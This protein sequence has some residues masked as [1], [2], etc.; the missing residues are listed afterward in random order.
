MN[1]TW[2]KLY[3]GLCAMAAVAIA[4]VL[5]VDYFGYQQQG[6]SRI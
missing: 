2:R 3:L 6:L 1:R 5:T 4:D